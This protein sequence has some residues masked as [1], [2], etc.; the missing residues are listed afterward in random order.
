MAGGA[1]ARPTI[2][3]NLWE[4][5]ARSMCEESLSNGVHRGAAQLPTIEAN[6]W[7]GIPLSE[8]V[9]P[10]QKAASFRTFFKSGL[11]P[12]PLFWTPLR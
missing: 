5:K 1:A 10:Q 3:A 12:P 2:E 7:A 8:G 11:A 6:L 4:D 9:H